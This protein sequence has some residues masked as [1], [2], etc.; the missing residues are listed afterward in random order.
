MENLELNGVT[1]DFSGVERAAV[2]ND[3]F[4]QDCVALQG[5]APDFSSLKELTFI[6][7]GADLEHDQPKDQRH[8]VEIS[9]D[10]IDMTSQP[11]S[12]GNNPMIPDSSKLASLLEQAKSVRERVRSFREKQ[13][14]TW[15]DMDFRIAVL[16]SRYIDPAPKNR[17]LVRLTPRRPTDH[18][19]SYYTY[20][21]EE[22][23]PTYSVRIEELNCD[24]PCLPDGTPVGRYHGLEKLF[25]EA[26]N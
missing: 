8:L 3:T 14:Q 2:A 24:A 20:K 13:P 15:D 21:P 25:E 10:L 22:S 9:D 26:E 23:S 11:P 4:T 1:P 19:V 12:F 7:G 17:E 6:I 16:A 18:D 5:F